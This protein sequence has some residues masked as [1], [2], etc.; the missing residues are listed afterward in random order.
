MFVSASLGYR[1]CMLTG[2]IDVSLDTVNLSLFLLSRS[3][4]ARPD[5]VRPLRYSCTPAHAPRPVA[6]YRLS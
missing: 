5:A 6:L 4:S 2:V 3:L 1:P